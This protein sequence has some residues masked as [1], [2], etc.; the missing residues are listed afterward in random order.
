MLLITLIQKKSVSMIILPDKKEG[1][2][3]IEYYTNSGKTEILNIEGSEDAWRVSSNAECRIKEDGK[4]VQTHIINDNDVFMAETEGEEC[5]VLSEPVVQ[6]R[7]R[8]KKLFLKNS[9]AVIS[10]GQKKDNS[11]FINSKYISGRHAVIERRNGEWSVKD[12][13]SRNGTY[14]NNKRISESGLKA[15]DVIFI[16]GYKF[17]IGYDFIAANIYDDL[18]GYDSNIFY[19]ADKNEIILTEKP[20]EDEEQ[21]QYFYRT[22]K[23]QNKNIEEKNLELELP[24]DKEKKENQSAVLRLGPSFTMCSGS[25]MTAGYSVLASY[26]RGTGFSYV[27]PSIIMAGTMMCSAIMW[28]VVLNR[29]TKKSEIRKNRER[30]ELYSGYISNARAEIKR[31]LNDQSDIMNDIYYPSVRCAGLAYG[32][33]G[34]PDK[35]LWCKNIRSSD[36]LTVCIGKGDT[37]PLIRLKYPEKKLTVNTDQLTDNLY[38]LVSEERKLE[39]VNIP[40]SLKD[41]YICGFTGNREKSEAFVKALV[42]QLTSLYSYDEL[43]LIF[44]YNDNEA[45]KWDYA[46]WLPHV[47]NDNN[48]FRYVASD[49]LGVKELSVQLEKEISDRLEEKECTRPYV[50]LITADKELT[51][52][53]T[54]VSLILKNYKN[55][56]FSMFTLFDMRNYIDSDIIFDVSENGQA[57]MYKRGS[58]DEKNTEQIFVPDSIDDSTFSDFIDSISNIK[59]DLYAERYKLPQ[60]L[61]FLEMFGV[62]K[63]E[64]LNC[65][66]RWYENDPSKSLQTPIGVNQSGDSFYIDL[67]EKFHGPHGLIAGTTGSG[68]SETIITFILSLA[69]N[70]SPEEIS[71]LIIDYKGGGLAD[72]FESVERVTEDGK[73]TEKTV[74]L[75]H[76]AGTVTNLD[77]ATIERSRISIESELKRRQNLFKKARKI[78]GEGT[79]DIYKYQKLRR[80]GADFEALPHLFIVCDEFAELKSQQPEFMDSLVSTARIGRSLGVHLILATQKP[81]SVVSPQIWSNS[82]F[83]IC[84]KVQDKSDSTA[85]I[86]CPDAAEIQ[87]T[88]RFYLQVGYNELFSLGQSAWCG[89]DYT[90]NGRIQN[91]AAKSAELINSTGTVLC[92]KKIKDNTENNNEHVSSELVAVRQYLISMA[93]NIQIRP[94]W[95]LPL[96]SFISLEQL[97]NEYDVPSGKYNLEPI[98]GKWDDLYERQQHIMTVPFSEKGN[99][100][101]YSS[102]GGGMDSFFITLIYSLIYRYTAEEVNIYILEFDSGYLR[103]FEKTP[104]VGNVVMA[105]ENDDVIR[106][107]AELR[108]EIIKRNKLFAPY[109]GEYQEYCRRSGSTLP[110]VVLML[111]NYVL[112]NEE[113]DKYVSELAYISREGIKCGVYIVLGSASININSRLKQNIGQNYMLRMNDRLD[114]AAVLGRTDGIIPSEYSG[115]GLVRYGS[116]VYEF[117]TAD[118][119][120]KEYNEEN[121]DAPSSESDPSEKI[122]K[123]CSKASASSSVS[124]K[125]YIIRAE[126]ITADELIKYSGGVSSVP[127]GTLSGSNEICTADFSDSYITFVSA[128]SEK[129]LS[130][131]SLYLA[132]TMSADESADIILVDPKCMINVPEQRAFTYI[133][134]AEG[135]DAWQEKYREMYLERDAALEKNEKGEWY[136]SDSFRHVYIIINLFEATADVSTMCMVRFIEAML[137]CEIH[138]IS[139]IVTDTPEKMKEPAG[140]YERII[141]RGNRDKGVLFLDNEHDEWFNRLGIW[142][143]ENVSKQSLFD[144]KNKLDITSEKNTGIIIQNE[145][146]VVKFILAGDNNG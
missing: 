65:L 75:P 119:L 22:I 118:I 69:V 103:I 139:Y 24:P 72:A 99:L 34:K 38:Q 28:P 45:D 61:T 144:I 76:L 15:G 91:K 97:Y 50:L 30:L 79:M 135:L 51:E 68:K 8:Y 62:S 54:P 142:L 132:E 90:Q 126:Q 5:I 58:E 145:K 106:L 77:G 123:L 81:D 19:E 52:Q 86:R 141:V 26:Y 10:I 71:F 111:N 92:E 125:Q 102:P 78:S 64:H 57:C 29:V 7:C 104:Q 27:V 112:F 129:L 101:I 44:I 143:G 60:M 138:N 117:Q 37:D 70:Y 96:P 131:F 137:G 21:K 48:T 16:L 40:L 3:G 12:Q 127:L 94:L 89:A 9:D 88:G 13:D 83:K 14:L 43:K 39:N 56:R 80:N 46:G 115:R 95:L 130:D 74:K 113:Y 6:E 53:M 107:L 32:A 82:R 47:W 33:D 4:S 18:A 25:V 42:V 100:C 49:S 136:L 2:Y 63:V 133:S 1:R 36:F 67:H 35:Y 110:N 122:E 66:T 140:C 108:Q 84:L 55:I 17:I 85:V 134:G 105:D 121:Q 128:E 114:Y 124:A 120:D 93:G 20:A 87:A 59:L 11:I 146:A 116:H 98:I 109:G 73:I 41:G 31:I 23:L